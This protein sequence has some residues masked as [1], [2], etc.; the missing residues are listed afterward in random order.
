MIP[1]L[2]TAAE[3]WSRADIA[4]LL[5]QQN[6]ELVALRRALAP[7]SSCEVPP[8]AP[9]DAFNLV[10]K[11][12][13]VRRAQ[14]LLASTHHTAQLGI[15]TAPADVAAPGEWECRRTPVYYELWCVRRKTE[16]QLGQ[17]FFGQRFHIPNKDEALALTKLLNR[18]PDVEGTPE[19][20]GTMPVSWERP[21]HG[22]PS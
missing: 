7:F 19:P 18:A 2:Q 20:R 12:A 5:H 14:N 8:L 1:T 22:D 6:Q 9:S 4:A 21:I 15:E 16:R 11:A 3:T 10:V 17:M 13:D